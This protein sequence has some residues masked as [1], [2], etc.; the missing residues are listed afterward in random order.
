MQ[1]ARG[2]A[3]GSLPKGESGGAEAADD[4]VA[5]QGGEVADGAEAPLIKNGSE[6]RRGLGGG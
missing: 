5:G 2:A 6:F 3:G 1:G 4:I